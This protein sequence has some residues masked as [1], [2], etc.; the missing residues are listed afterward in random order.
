MLLANSKMF[1]FKFNITGTLF[2]IYF[3]WKNI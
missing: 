3:S 2:V 1:R